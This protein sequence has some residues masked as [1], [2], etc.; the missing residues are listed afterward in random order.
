MSDFFVDIHCHPT[1]RAMNTTPLAGRR[2]HWDATKNDFT[3]TSLGR[4]AWKSS[5]AISKHSQSNF[6]SC[7]EGNLRVVFDSLYPLERGFVNYKKLPR[8]IGSEKTFETM[9]V[10]ATGLSVKQYRLFKA[11][12]DYFADLQEQYQFLK[13]NEGASPCGKFSYKL[14]NNFSEL[15]QSLAENSDTI[16]V[17]V[18]I[19][20]AHVFGTGRK[21]TQEIP[22]EDLMLLVQ[23]NI[24][25]VKNWEHPPFFMTFAHHFWNQLCGH[26]TTLKGASKMACDQSKG[27]YQGFTILG[28]FVLEQLLSREN[29][30]RI[31]IDTR[32][33]SVESR[34]YYI[35][36]VQHHNLAHPDDLIPI[37]SSH[38]GMNGFD[39]MQHSV[40]QKDDHAKIKRTKFFAWSLNISGEEARAI[41]QSKGLAGI[42][43]DKGRHSGLNLVKKV[44]KIKDPVERKEAFVKMLLDCIFCFV[45]AINEKSAWDIVTLGTDF[46][47]VIEHFDFYENMSTLPQLKSDLIAYL[48]KTNY[49]QALWFNYE[50]E[51]L[52]S[53][54]FTKNSMEFLKRNFN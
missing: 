22:E 52:M 16:H 27:L 13:S 19:E 10:S 40:R 41:H 45:G 1:M 49:Q 46:D 29:G 2:N 53:K 25:T 32:H 6:Y 18:T 12:D 3:D 54:F 20:G 35:D 11:N 24:A 23:K 37:I 8:M 5:E 38:S 48:K 28:K 26:S 50:P 4:W 42:M 51:E 7:I 14:P 47:G 30:K 9:M 36:F 17:I 31:L 15:E 44:E 33:M 34:K 39:Q 43:L 21:E